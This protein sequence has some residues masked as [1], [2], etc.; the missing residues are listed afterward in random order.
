[1]S[2]KNVHLNT[3]K[4]RQQKLLVADVFETQRV[5]AVFSYIKQKQADKIIATAALLQ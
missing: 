1:M 2:I 3:G 5:A 4:G